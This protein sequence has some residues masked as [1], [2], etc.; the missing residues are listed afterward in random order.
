MAYHRDYIMRMMEMMAEMIAIFLGLIKKG[1]LQQAR[2]QLNRAY[3]DLLKQDASFFFF[4][5][6]DCL[7]DELISKHNY[8]NN[9]LKVLSELFF[10]EGKLQEKLNNSPEA[11]TNYKKAL[12]L[13]NFIEQEASTFSMTANNRKTL[14]KSRI[15]ELTI[16]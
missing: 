2:K 9:H 16:P 5:Y 13:L 6:I 7:T 12:L 15:Q 3:L 14:I 11:I 10:A 8:T 4:F 1:D